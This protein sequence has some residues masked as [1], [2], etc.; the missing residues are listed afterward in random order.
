MVEHTP[1]Y[2]PDIEE[3]QLTGLLPEGRAYM[4]HLHVLGNSSSVNFRIGNL[5]ISSQSLKEALVAPLYITP[6]F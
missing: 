6:L 2:C 1:I 4:L 5:V 3:A